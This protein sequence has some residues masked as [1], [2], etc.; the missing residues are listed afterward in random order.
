MEEYLKIDNIDFITIEEIQLFM[1]LFADDT[2]LFSY[3]ENG[4]QQLLNKLH[5]YC[6]IWG[7]SVNIDKSFVM[8]CKKGNRIENVNLLYD[9][10]KL[11]A[12]NK[13][14]YLGI[15]LSQNGTYLQAQKK[16]SEQA[17]RA[18]FSLNSLFDVMLLDIR[19]K[20]KLFDCMISPILN[21]GSEV[22]GF[23]KAQDIE[24]VQLKFLKQILGVRQQSCNAAVYGELARFPLSLF[25]K[26]RI[27]KY[28]FKVKRYPESLMYKVFNM[29]SVNGEYINTWTVNLKQLLN[30]LG[31]AYLFTCDNVT[32]IQIEAVVRRI[33]DTYLQQWY[34][35]V[36][37]SDKLQCYVNFKQDF[38]IEKYLIC[39]NS[40]KL[41][42]RLTRFR[43][44]AH[45]LNIEEGRYRNIN[46]EDR[47]CNKCNMNVVENEYHFLLVCPH[48]LDLRTK[49]IPRYYIHWPNMTKFNNLMSC[50]N[51]KI[52]NNIAT[53]L[54]FA[55]DRR[56][57]A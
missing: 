37:N 47:K 56:N 17:L 34:T 1:L 8:V 48:Y 31:F 21:Y 16:L 11:D 44:S 26:I 13:F 40:N 39:I 35:N 51:D 33:Y 43:C 19:D 36:R 45:N 52:L 18:L 2:V 49:Y 54:S 25:R 27:I 24:R 38:A 32:N 20:L 15:T 3:T 4:L 6:N 50:N 7:I 53:Y 9:G 42:I 22:W 46:R 12:V 55:T 23:H 28:W 30:E 29:K 10:H 14:I 57:A 5:N 41:R